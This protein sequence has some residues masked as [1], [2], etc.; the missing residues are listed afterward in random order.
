MIEPIEISIQIDALPPVVWKHLTDPQHMKCWMGS[1][2]MNLQIHTS[3]HVGDSIRITGHHHIAFENK[4]TV[5]RFEPFRLLQYTHLDSISCLAD[6]PE[7]HTHLTFRLDPQDGQTV[8]YLKAEEFPTETIYKH[9]RFY[10]QGT[11][12]LLRNFIGQQGQL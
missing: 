1:P 3:W 11:L 7:N 12:V 8:L 2:E 4:G 10:W 6:I 5:L 9:L